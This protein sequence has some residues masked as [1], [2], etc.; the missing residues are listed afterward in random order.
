MTTNNSAPSDFG[1]VCE[2]LSSAIISVAYHPMCPASVKDDL[3]G[4]C[5]DL[6]NRSPGVE[7]ERERFDVMF[8]FSALA[9]GQ[10]A[11]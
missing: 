10:L 1:A 4:L 5:V 11:E 3:I 8:A 6:G 2:Q 9:N 7:V